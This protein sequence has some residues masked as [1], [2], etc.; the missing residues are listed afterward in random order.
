MRHLSAPGKPSSFPSNSPATGSSSF[1]LGPPLG[2]I[3]HEPLHE[4]AIPI[5][6]LNGVGVVQAWS[7]NLLLEKIGGIR[8]GSLPALVFDY[9]DE[10]ALG[11]LLVLLLTKTVGHAITGMLLPLGFA[12][13]AIEDGSDRFLTR[14]VTR[15]EI[16]E[17]LGGP[18]ILP[19]EL[20]D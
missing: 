15:G 19:S 7:L 18:P 9:G 20:V 1:L 3:Q 11:P 17:L 12:L 13:V 5:G 6:V 2:S 14:G 16:E 4:G 8:V 10:H